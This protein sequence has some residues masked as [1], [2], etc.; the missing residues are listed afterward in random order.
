MV[1]QTIASS[2]PFESVAARYLKLIFALRRAW[3]FVHGN[4]PTELQHECGAI[5]REC[6]DFAEHPPVI[7][8][9]L[10]AR[11][12]TALE[13]SWAYVNIPFVSQSA[14]SEVRQ[15]LVSIGELDST[16]PAPSMSHPRG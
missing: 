14:K 10:N 16:V 1:L 8:E 15:A 13:R 7:S 5:M 3:P 12:Y 11:I 2:S 4:A 9:E 6:G